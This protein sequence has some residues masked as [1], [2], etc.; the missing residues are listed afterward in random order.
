M[1][2]LRSRSLYVNVLAI[3]FLI[4]A[5]PIFVRGLSSE[6]GQSDVAYL[7]YVGEFSGAMVKH[8][9]VN[10][11]VLDHKAEESVFAIHPVIPNSLL[12]KLTCASSVEWEKEADLDIGYYYIPNEGLQMGQFGYAPTKIQ[13]RDPNDKLEM[14]VIPIGCF[15]TS[16]W[17]RVSGLVLWLNDAKERAE[18][19]EF[20][21]RIE[22][23][24]ENN[25]AKARV[26]WQETAHLDWAL[27][28]DLLDLR[29]QQTRLQKN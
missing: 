7:G 3:A 5:S 23:P 17:S 28:K 25:E 8:G 11:K 4:L 27:A 10:G 9:E 14:F 1:L 26:Y 15:G 12:R 29:V 21:M 24:N 19:M 2:S 18:V 6:V 16:R 13:Y 20:S 22:L